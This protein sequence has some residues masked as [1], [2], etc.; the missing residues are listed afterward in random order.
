MTKENDTVDHVHSINHNYN[1]LFKVQQLATNYS[2]LLNNKKYQHCGRLEIATVGLHW[3]SSNDGWGG[4]KSFDP[5]NLVVKR[6][7]KHDCWK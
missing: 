7:Q 2:Q 4:F 1:Y 5:C 6:E 3:N